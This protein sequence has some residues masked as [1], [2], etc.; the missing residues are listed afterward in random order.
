MEAAGLALRSVT[1]IYEFRAV[2]MLS[3]DFGSREW[4]MKSGNFRL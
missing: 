1:L 2:A 3:I 4:F